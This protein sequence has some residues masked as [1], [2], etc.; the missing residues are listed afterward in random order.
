MGLEERNAKDETP[1][2]VAVS[3]QHKSCIEVLLDAGASPNARP[4]G[5]DSM[6]NVVVSGDLKSIAKLLLG[7]GVDVEERNGNGESPLFRA[8]EFPSPLLSVPIPI[9]GKMYL[10]NSA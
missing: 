5:K 7:R 3:R 1:L 6:L 2:W 4:I 10:A 9:R 8:G